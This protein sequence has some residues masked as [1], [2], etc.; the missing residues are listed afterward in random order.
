MRINTTL[1]TAKKLIGFGV[2]SLYED[3]LK[4]PPN[5]GNKPN[6]ASTAHTNLILFIPISV[7]PFV[8]NG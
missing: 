6:K 2:I 4:Q 1:T 3:W 5:P 8:P 7:S